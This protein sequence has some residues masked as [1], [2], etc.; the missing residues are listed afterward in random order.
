M[1]KHGMMFLAILAFALP[2]AACA[3]DA[4]RLV[5]AHW[6]LNMP[7]E[8]YADA[9]REDDIRAG[10]ELGLNGFALEGFNKIAA[11][12]VLYSFFKAADTIGAK[13][14]K[15]FLSA[16]ASATFPAE[17]IVA[18][19]KAYGNSPHYLKVRGKPL[20]STWAG[21][22]YG[23]DWWQD[24]VLTPLKEAGME[25]TFIP[26]FERADENAVLPT[27]DNWMAV[28]KK[29]PSIDGLFNFRLSAT[30][31][32]YTS[33][34][35]LGNHKWSM[36]EGEENLAQAL[37]DSHKMF[38]APFLIYYWS[39][40]GSNVRPYNE[41][42][43]GRGMDNW[44]RSIINKQK[45]EMVSII[46]WNDYSE[47]TFIQPTRFPNTKFPAVETLPHLGYYE[48]L[49]YY[50]SW[51]HSGHAPK[52]IRDGVFFFY[53]THPNDAVASDD[54]SACALG[55]IPPDQKWG[56]VKDVIYVTTALTEPSV[57]RVTTGGAVH[58]IPV[59]AG[60]HTVDVPFK[61]GHQTFEIVRND[62]VRI[63]I[64]GA[65]ILDNIKVYNFNVYSGYAIA[66][67]P[68]SETWKPSDAWKGGFIADWFV[69]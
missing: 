11:N 34:P 28:I 24:K 6:W 38:M 29:F 44:W 3:Q 30:T 69:Q 14:F 8:K 49:K 1:T 54:I 22:E 9:S 58:D 2:H 68:T 46:T 39:V 32:F 57:L 27:Y 10:M 13:D 45:P 15:F 40:C 63:H 42:Q 12:N 55:P 7:Y 47:S 25:V 67:G 64:S 61:A 35:N 48:L 18:I 66:N 33:D 17:D 21:G 53:R 26:N 62:K 41:H 16:D 5:V 51:Y 43:G 60:M 19:V 31:P 56:V 36:L 20:L 23:N 52:I 50:I 65:D 59:P 37:R 4:G